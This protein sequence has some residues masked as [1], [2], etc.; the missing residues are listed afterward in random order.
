MKKL[1]F[2]CSLILMSCQTSTCDKISSYISEKIATAY[3]C[4]N[5]KAFYDKVQSV[6][7]SRDPS[8]LIGKLACRLTINYIA[9]NINEFS[10]EGKCKK[11]FVSDETKEGLISFCSTL[12][13]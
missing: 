4:E 12:V 2:I 13:P 8:S 5:P 9:D 3:E 10:L 6:C 11:D 7:P 1:L